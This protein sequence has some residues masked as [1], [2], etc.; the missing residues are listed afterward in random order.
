MKSVTASLLI[1]IQE[2]KAHR[3]MTYSPLNVNVYVLM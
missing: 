3:E 2:E 1:V